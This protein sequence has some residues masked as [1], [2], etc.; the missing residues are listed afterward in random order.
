MKYYVLEI[1]S[2]DAKIAGSAVYTYDDEYSA[3]SS[4]HKK[5]GTAMASE[6]YTSELVMVINSVG[7]VIKSEYWKAEEVTEV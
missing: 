7:G 2:G 6:L 3:V 1:A 4:F 5:M